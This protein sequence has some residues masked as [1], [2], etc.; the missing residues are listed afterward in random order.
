M[1]LAE[2]D[3]EPGAEISL[4]APILMRMHSVLGL[5]HLGIVPSLQAAIV[6]AFALAE[7]RRGTR[8]QGTALCQELFLVL[9]GT[10]SELFSACSVAGKN[11]AAASIVS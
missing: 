9:R 2:T 1:F 7:V 6:D 5:F 3:E 8:S 10:R 11:K 4:R